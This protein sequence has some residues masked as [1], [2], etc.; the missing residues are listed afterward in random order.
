[1]ELSDEEQSEVQ[2]YLKSLIESLKNKEKQVYYV[3]CDN[4]G[5]H[6][7]LKLY[8]DEKGI[9]LE[10]TAPNTPQYNGVVERGFE[11]HL[12]CVRAMLYQANFMTEMAIKL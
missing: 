10:M 8:C 4:V 3:R 9:N 7:P 2:Y 1:M 11:I 5:E 6:E 12:N